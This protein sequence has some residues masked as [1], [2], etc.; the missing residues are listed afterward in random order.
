MKAVGFN[1]LKVHPFQAKP[2]VT[3]VNLHPYNEARGEG[4]ACTLALLTA[5]QE[6]GL[7]QTWHKAM[8]HMRNTV[9][10]RCKLTPRS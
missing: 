5:M 4:G 8:T 6:R 1:W 9:G 2:S 3:N 7:D 10:R